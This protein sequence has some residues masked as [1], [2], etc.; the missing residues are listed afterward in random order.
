MEERKLTVIDGDGGR[1]AGASVGVPIGRPASVA[2]GTGALET[3]HVVVRTGPL[4]LGSHRVSASVIFRRE[5]R[6]QPE[7]H[8]QDL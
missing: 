2:K 7:G 4:D 3:V 1:F 6:L 5:C 8:Q